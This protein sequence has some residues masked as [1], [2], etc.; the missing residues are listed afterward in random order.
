MRQA[1]EAGALYVAT[2]SSLVLD[3]APR[4]D[5]ILELVSGGLGDAPAT[6]DIA[7]WK[8]VEGQCRLIAVVRPCGT[9]FID[10]VSPAARSQP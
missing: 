1:E 7:I 6:S 8:Q 9:V 5:T 10:R 3:D 4:L 2:R